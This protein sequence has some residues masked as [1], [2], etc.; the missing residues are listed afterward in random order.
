LALPDRR[1]PPVD[2]R[3]DPTALGQ[4]NEHPGYIDR[5]ARSTDDRRF[6]DHGS[7]GYPTIIKREMG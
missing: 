6:P 3:N 5:S 1:V 4:S 7:K 2:R